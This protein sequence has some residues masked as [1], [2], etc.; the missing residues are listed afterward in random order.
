MQV[1]DRRSILLPFRLP[2]YQKSFVVINKEQFF[3]RLLRTY[4]AQIMEQ[5]HVLVRLVTVLGNQYGYNFKSPG[6]NFCEPDSVSVKHKQDSLFLCFC[7]EICNN[8]AKNL[9]LLLCGDDVAERLT[10]EVTCELGYA[11]PDGMQASILSSHASHFKVN[12]TVKLN[13]FCYM[14]IILFNQW[15][16]FQIFDKKFNM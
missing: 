8:H 3:S 6:S 5:F 15:I 14:Y 16:S 11:T 7:I 12:K 4:V 13:I 1:Y 2:S 10:Y 9:Q